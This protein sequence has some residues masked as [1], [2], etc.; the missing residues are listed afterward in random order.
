MH[1][2][3]PQL[4]RRVLLVLCL[5]GFAATSAAAQDITKV[6]TSGVKVV[7]ENDEVRI[8]DV[9]TQP[10][11]K[12]AL[13][14]HPDMMTITLT[15]GTTKFTTAAGK[16]ETRGA[17]AKPGTAVYLTAES[18]SSQNVG[19]T[20]GHVILIEF[21]KPAPAAE[22]AAHPSLPA[23]Y[24]QVSEN[25]YAV[26]FELIV[27]PGGSVPQHTHGNYVLVALADGTA[28]LTNQDGS[29][30]ILKLVKDTAT[31]QTAVTHSGVN[32]G[33]SPLHLIAVELK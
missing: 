22:M 29:K 16:T 33:N 1:R 18:H 26:E 31:Y 32:T 21:K 19:R 2:F 3:S 23:P 17:D 28:E 4:T 10:G 9:V 15:P 14:T 27:P 11:S 6:A 7:F 12:M 13:H 25:A 20:A 8:L 30:Q 24:K 5:L